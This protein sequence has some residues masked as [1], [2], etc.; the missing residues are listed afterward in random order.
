MAVAAGGFQGSE[1]KLLFRQTVPSYR[2][3]S[4]WRSVNPTEPWRG[5][6]SILSQ[7]DDVHK[8]NGRF[9]FKLVWPQ[10]TGQNTQEWKQAR[11]TALP[12]ALRMALPLALPMALRMAI[13][14]LSQRVALAEGS[15]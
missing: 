11:P 8:V 1:W 12:L 6:F 10:R 13:V 7:L 5:D 2:P 14:P 3:P 9:H 4:Q 15:P